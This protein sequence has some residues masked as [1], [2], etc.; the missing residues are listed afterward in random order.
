MGLPAVSL[1]TRA[2]RAALVDYPTPSYDQTTGSPLGHSAAPGSTDLGASSAMA[3]PAVFASVR[4]IA[5][6]VATL[7]LLTYRRTLTG[8]DRISDDP[9]A[10]LLHDRPNDDQTA[11][12]MWEQLVGVLL[13]RG[14]G[15]LW[16]DR[17]DFFGRAASLRVLNPHGVRFT[18][19]DVTGTRYWQV[20][21]DSPE[22]IDE[23]D[24]IPVRAFMGLSPVGVCRQAVQLGL[25][26][27]AYGAKLWENDARPGGYLKTEQ[28]LTDAAYERM[29]AE[30]AAGHQGVDNAHRFGLLEGGV[31]WQDV[32]LP[33][34][35]AQFL[36]TRK[37]QITE[38]ARMFRIPPHKIGDLDRATFSNIEHQA[39]EYVQDTI[40]PWCI[41][42]EQR[43]K[44]G[45]FGDVR[46][47][48]VFAEFLLEGLLRGDT[49]SRFEAYGKAPWMS[50]NDKRQRENLPPL[51]GLDA[52]YAP[53]NMARIVDGE[54][55]P[56]VA[57]APPTGVP[58]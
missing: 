16:I 17:R 18:R 22:R 49:A 6:T 27:Q 50:D 37:F 10:A 32:G 29:R 4:V 33:P 48:D 13:Q 38:V 39:I 53:L 20:G 36:E 9:R 52:T 26:A 47:R 30:W 5:E 40:M 3:F 21:F 25:N 45:I 15:H 42:L 58:A 34:E 51:P 43:I 7:P 44:R 14:T 46:D 28:S 35:D 19:D 8:R 23:G 54:V 56:P 24:I 55:V 1:A 41:R 2:A 12:E 31:S 11:V 57:A